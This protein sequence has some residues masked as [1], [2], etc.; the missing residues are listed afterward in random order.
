MDKSYA[1]MEL[2]I[3]AFWKQFELYG[4][5]SC[6]ESMLLR[7]ADSLWRMSTVVDTTHVPAIH[8]A[9]CPP[10]SIEIGRSIL[11]DTEKWAL[12]AKVRREETKIGGKE[13]NKKVTRATKQTKPPTPGEGFPAG[14]GRPLA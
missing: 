7:Q 9:L 8:F 5:A 6:N 12:Q 3:E 1:S 10:R 2:S 13:Y 14:R 4:T 11:S